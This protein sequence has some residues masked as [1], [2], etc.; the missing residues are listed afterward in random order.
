MPSQSERELRMIGEA[1]EDRAYTVDVV[2][3]VDECHKVRVT[4]KADGVQVYSTAASW[5][6]SEALTRAAAAMRAD[7]RGENDG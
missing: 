1:E 2:L 6:I 5:G 4:R 7:V 3:G